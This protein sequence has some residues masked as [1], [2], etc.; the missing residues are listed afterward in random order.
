MRLNLLIIK[1][2]IIWCTDSS[3]HTSHT[4][5]NHVELL[6]LHQ[7]LALLKPSRG[8]LSIGSSRGLQ[9]TDPKKCEIF[10]SGVETKNAEREEQ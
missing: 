7:F 5:L 6:Y 1:N 3:M 10:V 4:P 8:P 9:E 2:E